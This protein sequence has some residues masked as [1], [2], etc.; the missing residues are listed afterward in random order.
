MFLQK[1]VLKTTAVVGFQ[2]SVRLNFK[3]A[4]SRGF[5]VL[6]CLRHEML[7]EKT[8]RKMSSDFLS[9]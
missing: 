5:S 9:R 1:P 8:N 3:G 6:A 4:R 2:G 7:L